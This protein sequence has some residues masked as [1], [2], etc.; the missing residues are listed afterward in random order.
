MIERKIIANYFYILTTALVLFLF[1]SALLL[2]LHSIDLASKIQE[3]N[4]IILELQDQ[5][6]HD[7]LQ[8]M[9]SQMKQSLQLN[10][11]DIELISKNDAMKMMGDDLSEQLLASGES[12]PF[13]DLILVKM[14]KRDPNYLESL[15][16]ILISFRMVDSIEIE[17]EFSKEMGSL[18][19]RISTIMLFISIAMLV[20]TAIII[21]FL[22]T[23]FLQER[24]DVMSVMSTLGTPVNKITEP[25][26]KQIL[27]YSVVSSLLAIG[28][29]SI[30][31]LLCKF[32][33]PWLYD[34]VELVKF[35]I[36]IFVLLILGPSLHYI[37]V[38]SKILK[39]LKY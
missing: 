39:L 3:Q 13:R 14:K 17:H 2:W 37:M 18:S 8:M 22:V 6:S 9:I 20:I 30:A 29:I 21:S 32:I 25:Y 24:M 23:I 1:G 11:K 36:V 26:L 35:F 38:K 19:N 10:E 16:K 33:S 12:N 15:K 5:Y 4:P 31:I 34:L 27:I 7:S 28:F